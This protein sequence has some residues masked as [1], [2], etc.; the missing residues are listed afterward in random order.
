M[1]ISLG[2]LFVM[3]E[4]WEGPPLKA[5][6]VGNHYIMYIFE[7]VFKTTVFKKYLQK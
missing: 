6:F 7:F 3:H 1:I 5:V 2:T 4:A